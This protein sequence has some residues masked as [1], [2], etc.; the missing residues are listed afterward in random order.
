VSQFLLRSDDV[1]TWSDL[2]AWS[3]M[4]GN[5]VSVVTENEF[6]IERKRS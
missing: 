2:G 5:D 1:A 4:T 6:M 3:R